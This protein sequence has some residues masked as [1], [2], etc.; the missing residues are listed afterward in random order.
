MHGRPLEEI[1]AIFIAAW[2]IMFA[3]AVVWL[4]TVAWLF[5]RLRNNHEAQ[6]ES[7]GSPTLFWNNSLR[8]QW[9]L[10]KF[11]FGSQWKSLNDPVLATACSIMRAFLCAY[12]VGF[13][14]FMA[15]VFLGIGTSRR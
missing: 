8:N 7:L 6:Y 4:A 10:A 9:L 3:A 12:L 2:A 13:V 15:T 5:R 14:I 11:L 1:P